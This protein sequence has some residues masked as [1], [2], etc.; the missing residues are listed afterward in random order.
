MYQYISRSKQYMSEL[1]RTFCRSTRMSARC[2]KDCRV[3]GTY[4][5]SRE[6]HHRRAALRQGRSRVAFTEHRVPSL[7]LPWLFMAVASTRREN[8]AFACPAGMGSTCCREPRSSSAM[9]SNLVHHTRNRRR[10]HHIGTDTRVSTPPGLF[11]FT[12]LE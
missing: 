7:I 11:L 8:Q 3:A 10:R 4:R 12:I 9:L 6:R 5:V 1:M 2:L